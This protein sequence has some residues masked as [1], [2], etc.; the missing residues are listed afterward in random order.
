MTGRLTNRLQLQ[1]TN[2]C[3]IATQIYGSL[4]DTV[5]DQPTPAS[6]LPFLTPDKQSLRTIVT[7][8]KVNGISR[9]AFEVRTTVEDGTIVRYCGGGSSEGW[10]ACP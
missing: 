9:L 1:S 7:C 8:V 10:Q 2:S 4:T 3:V 6:R 5:L